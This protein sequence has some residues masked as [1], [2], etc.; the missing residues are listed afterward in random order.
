MAENV[1]YTGVQSILAGYDLIDNPVFSIWKGRDLLFSYNDTDKEQSKACLSD[2]LEAWQAG[3]NSDML[4]ICFHP[5]KE[6][7]YITNKTPVCA[8]L[9]VRVNPVTPANFYL[10]MQ[11]HGQFV[12]G[13]QNDLLLK[14][15]NELESRLSAYEGEDDETEDITGLGKYEGMI[16]GITNL[17]NN[18]V[19]AGIVTALISKLGSGGNEENKL[20]SVA[21]IGDEQKDYNEALLY[22]SQVDSDFRNDIIRLANLARNNRGQ[23]NWLVSMLRKI[24]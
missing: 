17:L 1:M 22:L 6:A 18:P 7:K 2:N 9:Y 3:G 8:T 23:F 24:E 11:Q 10:P 21:G 20:R 13:T 19:I 12:S 5:E 15:I 4:K 14:K 16:N